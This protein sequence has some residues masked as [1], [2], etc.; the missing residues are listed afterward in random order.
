MNRD[1]ELD[2]LVSELKDPFI[3]RPERLDIQASSLCWLDGTRACGADCTA[4]NA[5]E[6]LDASG[7]PLDTPN[8]C[9]VLKYAGQLG[10][11][12]MALIKLTK[13]L[14]DAARSGPGAPPNPFGGK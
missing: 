6:G 8:K 4:F 5:E 7:L 1:D 10:S 9:L 12:G 11:G 13:Q 14:A 2:S 3:E